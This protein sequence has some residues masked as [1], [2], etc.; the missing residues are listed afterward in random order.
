[1][2]SA[3]VWMVVCVCVTLAGGPVATQKS[4][5][6]AASAQFNGALAIVGGPYAGV[7]DGAFRADLSRTSE[8]ICFGSAFTG[9]PEL[10]PVPI[11]GNCF[12]ATLINVQ[13]VSNLPLEPN[14]GA[15]QVGVS[16][17]DA[18]GY[19]YSLQF[20]DAY[21][22]PPDY[23]RG[24]CLVQVGG[25]CTSASMDSAE[26][27]YPGQSGESRATGPQGRLSVQIGRKKPVTLGLYDVPFQ[28]AITAQ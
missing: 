17:T 15:R 8:A 9:D 1:M 16:F 2:R 27:T 21:A 18:R 22:N 25:G 28:L 14:Y 5:G 11:T 19:A 20:G 12:E 13:G 3:A 26:G 4:K 6:V 23:A 10:V 24:T 7:I